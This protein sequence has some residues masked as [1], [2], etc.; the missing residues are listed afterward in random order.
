[1]NC[2]TVERYVDALLDREVDASTQLTIEQHVVSCSVCGERIAFARWLKEQLQREGK[3]EAPPAL[4]ARVT[5]ALEVERRPQL[6]FVRADVSWRATAAMAAVAL[7]VF[8]I[9]GA[10]QLKGPTS[11]ASVAPLFEDVVRAHTRSYPAEV[12]R[13]EQV[14][15][16]F[17]DKVGFDVRPVQF[18]D[19]GVRFVGARQAE[20]GGR[21]AVTLQYEARGRRM[22]VVAFR[23][24]AHAREVGEQIDTDGR[25]LR[26]VQVGNHLVP[27]VEHGGLIYAVVVDLDP[28]DRLRLAAHA[29]LPEATQ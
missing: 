11:M 22:T 2:Q 27:L 21:H 1:M 5:D 17:A 25:L 19:P 13:G 18:S 7:L 14:P 23:L 8:G 16:Y 9:G 10:L 29:L 24:P 26:Y 6:S 28:E 3:L 20:V 12:A 15:A 4:R